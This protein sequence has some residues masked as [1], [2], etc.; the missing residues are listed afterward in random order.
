MR[1]SEGVTNKQSLTGVL[2]YQLSQLDYFDIE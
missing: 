2:D 1:Y